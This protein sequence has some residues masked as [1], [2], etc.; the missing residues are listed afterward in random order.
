MPCTD[1]RPMQVRSIQPAT[2]LTSLGEAA[3]FLRGL[4]IAEHAEPLI[5]VM[6]AADEPEM[7]RRARQAF[8]TFAC[9]M[10]LPVR[11]GA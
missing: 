7:E 9:A 11:L 6:E 8:E 5:D 4:P 3:D 2:V 10:R 1:I